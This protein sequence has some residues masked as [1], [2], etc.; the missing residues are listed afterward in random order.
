MGLF[1]SY[2]PASQIASNVRSGDSYA[3]TG[4]AMVN[5]DYTANGL[6]QYTQSG[7]ITPTYDARGNLTSAGSTSYAYDS[8]NMLRSTSDGITFHYDPFDRLVEYDTTVSTRFVHDGAE[9]S[10]EVEWTAPDSDAST[11]L[12]V[13]FW[14]VVRDLRGGSDFIERAVCVVP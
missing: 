3:W 5:R 4:A 1:M 13:R 11:G 14:F 9:I 6:N 12:L 2:N 7:S 8:Q 10:T